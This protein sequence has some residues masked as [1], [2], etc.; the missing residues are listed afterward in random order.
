[1]EIKKILISKINPA[2]Y[3]PRLDLQPGDPDYKKLK[4]SIQEFGL[5]EPLIWN[6]KTGN[7]VGGHQRLKILIAEG[8]TEVDVSVVDLEDSKEK[9]L[10]LALN[11][12]SGDWD[13]PKLKDLLQELDTGDFDMEVTGFDD[14]ELEELMIQFHPVEEDDFDAQAEAEKITV[15][16]TKKGDIWLLDDH[17]LICGDST[18]IDCLNKLMNSSKANLIF[19]DPPYNVGYDYDWRESL[20]KGK[21]VSHRFFS[22]KKSDKE[23]QDFI[24]ETFKNAYDSSSDNANF[25]CWHAS[26]NHSIVE[27]GIKDAGWLISQV[28]IWLK[29]YPVLSLGQHFLRTFEPCLHGWKKSKKNFYNK[30][31]NYRDVINWDD[32][33]LLLDVWYEKRDNITEYRHPTQKPIR[34]AERGIKKSSKRG[35]IVLDLFGGSGS[36]MIACQQLE[37]R[38]YMVELDLIYCDVIVKRWEDYTGKKAEMILDVKV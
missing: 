36:T 8:K 33:D 17:R 35:D 32:F 21:K 26:R 37:R 16:T 23:Y 9:A 6:K 10:N 2:K 29:N 4:K 38:C 20:H 31:G 34:L 19:T 1:M 30:I 14:N 28:I 15:P 5:V 22:D 24:N 12:I 3:N 18:D 7:L 11:K 13:L 25:Y 27:R